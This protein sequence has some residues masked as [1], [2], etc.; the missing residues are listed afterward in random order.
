MEGSLGVAPGIFFFFFS[1]HTVPPLLRFL[2]QK[3]NAKAVKRNA[4][5]QRID[6]TQFWRRVDASKGRQK[7]VD[8]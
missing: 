6:A 2:W 4:E 3:A 8:F 1:P 7:Q 5:R